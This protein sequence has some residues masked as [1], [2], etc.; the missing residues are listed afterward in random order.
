[1]WCCS[2]MLQGCGS[3]S[4]RAFVSTETLCIATLL[5][6]HREGALR[7]IVGLEELEMLSQ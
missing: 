5:N 6:S 7:D 1:M 2:S 4:R 3:I